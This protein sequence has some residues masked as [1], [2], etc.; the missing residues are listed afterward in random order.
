M[1]PPRRHG[2]AAALAAEVISRS[3]RAPPVAHRL[4]E[5]AAAAVERSPPFPL[6]LAGEAARRSGVVGRGVPSTLA[7][8]AAPS[9]I[10]R[11][12]KWG[13]KRRRR[14]P[15]GVSPPSSRR[16]TGRHLSAERPLPSTRHPRKLRNLEERRRETNQEDHR[17][18][19]TRHGKA[20]G[21][22]PRRGRDVPSPH[23]GSL[24]C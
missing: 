9:T 23:L 11:A 19:G 24:H 13:E 5:G 21:T 14:R 15:V 17:G 8:S 12:S 16:P 2:K 18:G 20:P 6:G 3:A 22:K 10:A 7:G 1:Y 4:P